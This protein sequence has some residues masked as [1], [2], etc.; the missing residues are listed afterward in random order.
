MK[1]GQKIASIDLE[2][3]YDWFK[4]FNNVNTLSDDTYRPIIR[5]LRDFVP[6]FVNCQASL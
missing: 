2:I 4:K 5:N 1:E 3:R 6:Q